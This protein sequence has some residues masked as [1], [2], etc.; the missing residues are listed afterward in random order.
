MPTLAKYPND[1]IL[2]ID[3]D[4]IR[5]EDWLKAFIDTPHVHLY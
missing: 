3:G 1:L 4:L 5:N 2:I